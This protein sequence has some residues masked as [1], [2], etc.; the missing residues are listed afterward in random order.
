[1]EKIVNDCREEFEKE[2]LRARENRTTEVVKQSETNP[3]KNITSDTK[4]A[5][6][7][8][9]QIR[10]IIEKIKKENPPKT[11]ESASNKAATESS[12]STTSNRASSKSG[13]DHHKSSSS[14]HHNGHSHSSSHSMTRHTSFNSYYSSHHHHQHPPLYP[15]SGV[16]IPHPYPPSD[17]YAHPYD[18]PPYYNENGYYE[19]SLKRNKSASY[20]TSRDAEYDF[21]MKK[22]K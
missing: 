1:M 3:Q 11:A 9:D 8:N 4:Q 7:M 19:P 12:S 21:F 20:L 15:P 17:Y 16:S 6:P 18:M 22:F 14:S 2:R 13:S 5:E 10:A